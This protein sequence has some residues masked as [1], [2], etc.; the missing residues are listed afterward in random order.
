MIKTIITIIGPTGIGKTNLS[1]KLAEHFQ[2]EIISADSRQFYKEIPIGTA[3]PTPEELNKIKHHFIHHK[4]IFD[5]YNVGDFE[6]EVLNR[7]SN[8]HSTHNVLIV[9]GGSGLYIDAI[10]KGLDTFPEI[11]KN[12][13]KKLN[14]TFKSEGLLSLQEELKSVDPISYKNIDLNNPHRVIRALE[15]FRGTGNPYSSFLNK[16]KSIRNFNTIAIGLTAKRDVVYHL[17]NERVNLMMKKGLLE[18]VKSVYPYKDMNALNTVGYK[19]LFQH[20]DGIMSLEDAVSEIK[21]NSRRFAKR[22]FTWFNKQPN[23]K[24]F[25]YEENFESIVAFLEAKLRFSKN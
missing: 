1:L 25:N 22:Q 9:V 21:K 4:S 14:N 15:I 16:K 6:A 2:T 3:A 23:I 5:S 10:T 12:I 17:I 18:E 24:W 8:L 7:I 20:L 11:D 13:R 19:E